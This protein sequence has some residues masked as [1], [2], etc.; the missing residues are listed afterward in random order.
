[1]AVEGNMGK[2]MTRK[3]KFIGVHTNQLTDTIEEEDEEWTV[4]FAVVD[5]APVLHLPLG[6]LEV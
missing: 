4:V 5:I 6:G 1:M 2:I 3:F